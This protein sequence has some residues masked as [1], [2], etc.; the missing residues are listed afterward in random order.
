MPWQQTT[1][2][3]PTGAMRDIRYRDCSSESLA[4]EK[5]IIDSSK[6]RHFILRRS[7]ISGCIDRIESQDL[8]S[9]N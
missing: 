6:A 7:C 9:S 4:T 5:P 3:R 8:Y 1:G 2:R